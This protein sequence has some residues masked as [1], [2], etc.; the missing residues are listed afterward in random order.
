MDYFGARYYGSALGRWTSPD[1]INLT[2]ARL[3]NPTDT[4]NK[5]IYGGNNPLKYIDPDGRD[6][7]IYYRPP[8]GNLMDFGH[9]FLGA[10]NQDTG[11][12]KFLDF[13]PKNGTD[14]FGAGPGAFNMGNFQ[15]RAGQQFSSLTIQ[16]TPED[17]QKVIDFI[18]K[19]ESGNAPDYSVF[20]NNCTTVCQDALHD[21]GIDLGDIE[22][23]TFWADSFQKYSAKALARRQ[24]GVAGMVQNFFQPI[25]PQA[26]LGVEYG[27]PRNFG[28]G[29]FDLFNLYLNQL[30]NPQP[31]ACVSTYDS[32][33]GSYS[34][35]CQ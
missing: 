1:R 8:N 27:N 4:L 17:A 32:V 2:N 34:Q 35:T 23:A 9:V 19:L 33:S 5:Y 30:Q 10:L 16:T 28:P 15:D 11:A 7:T 22:P 13:Y 31:K 12:V 21:L 14:S 18:N 25:Q 6:I 29:K 3:F 20:S 26:Q 24:N